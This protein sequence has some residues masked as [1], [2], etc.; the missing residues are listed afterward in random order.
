MNSA[1]HPTATSLLNW[2]INKFG[3]FKDASLERIYQDESWPH[4]RKQLA[5]FIILVSVLQLLFSLGPIVAYGLDWRFYAGLGL[6]L[7]A[8][9]IWMYPLWLTQNSNVPAHFNIA[10]Y[11]AAMVE[12][13]VL[14]GLGAFIC[15]V[16]LDYS[17]HVVLSIVGTTILFY[18]SPQYLAWLFSAHLLAFL[19]F[20]HGLHSDL[21]YIRAAAYAL[22][23]SILG[24][25][26]S[27]YRIAMERRLFITNRL[28]QQQEKMNLLSAERQHLAKE[29]HDGLGSQLVG[30]LNSLQSGRLTIA[31]AEQILRSCIDDMRLV[32]DAIS[33][34]DSDLLSV[35]GNLR[36]RLDPRLR[37]TG[38][39]LY[40]KLV[41]MPDR[42][43]L[44]PVRVL[45]VLRI[46]QE[47]LTNII[48]HAQADTV[49]VSLEVLHSGEFCLEISDNGIGHERE[50]NP[51]GNSGKYGLVNMQNRARHLNGNIT[52]SPNQ[53][54][55]ILIRLVFPLKLSNE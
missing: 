53:T 37:Q 14:L 16:D 35:L 27:V 48:K 38:I 5:R 28:L 40:W 11:G 52:F 1:P 20:Y 15:V 2:H 44:S 51:E 39:T 50:I 32:V 30:A 31:D 9:A 36:Y 33:P 19:I 49:V 23:L 22:T 12:L 42:I 7:F 41:N 4:E 43:T 54:R 55:G 8:S 6:R 10:L 47:A 21:E 29:M 24:F 13:L 46:T 34:T 17:A 26:T 45:N 25:A 3:Q 18:R